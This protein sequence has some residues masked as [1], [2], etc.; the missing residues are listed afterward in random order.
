LS[1]QSAPEAEA[2]AFSCG[3]P[4]RGLT[5]RRSERPKLAITRATAPMF[6]ASCGATRMTAGARAAVSAMVAFSDRLAGDGKPA[7]A[8]STSCAHAGGICLATAPLRAGL[9][10]LYGPDEPSPTLAQE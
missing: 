4:S 1:G 10:R 8:Y 7:A 3:Q 5:S 9:R 2:Q 6:M